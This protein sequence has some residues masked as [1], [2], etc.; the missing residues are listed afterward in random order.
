MLQRTRRSP[1][2]WRPQYR[3]YPDHG[4][5]HGLPRPWSPP[6]A[7]PRG[8]GYNVQGTS[9]VP[10]PPRS[11]PPDQREPPPRPRYESYHPLNRSPEQIFYHILD[12]GLIRPP[13][14]IKKY[15]NMKRSLQYCVFHKDFGHSIAECFTLREEIESLILSGYLKEFVAG[16]REARKF[17]SRIRARG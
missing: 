16:M 14:P 7:A 8:R 11:P 17:R 15:P 3:G 1:K 4:A 10:E 2:G 6:R 5:L 9:R 13:K 12:I